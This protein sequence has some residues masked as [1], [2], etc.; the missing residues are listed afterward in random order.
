VPQKAPPAA[1]PEL[2]GHAFT[3]ATKSPAE[4]RYLSAEGR[5]AGAAETTKNIA[6][7]FFSSKTSAKSHVKPQNKLNHSKQAE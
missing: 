7:A 5:S 2:E 1:H 3:R 6:F 4:R